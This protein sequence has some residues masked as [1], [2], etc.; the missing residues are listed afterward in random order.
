MAVVYR[1]L[2]RT[3][4]PD[5]G[6]ACPIDLAAVDWPE[7]GAIQGLHQRGLDGELEPDRRA[8]ALNLLVHP[9]GGGR[10]T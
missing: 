9:G 2:A 6:R 10:D 4:L 3:W 8:S 5:V 7:L 1:H